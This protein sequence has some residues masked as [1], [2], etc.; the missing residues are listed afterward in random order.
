MTT[1]QKGWP[2]GENNLNSSKLFGIDFLLHATSCFSKILGPVRVPV[3]SLEWQLR[4]DHVPGV[5]HAAPICPD[6]C[7]H[8]M[9]ITIDPHGSLYDMRQKINVISCVVEDTC[10]ILSVFDC[11]C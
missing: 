6:P 9:L 1:C 8:D 11:L 7:N 4:V 2:Q 10:N 3:V 5:K